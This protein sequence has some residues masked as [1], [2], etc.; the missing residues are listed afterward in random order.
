MSRHLFL[1]CYDICDDTRLRHVREQ[2]SAWRVQGQKSAFECW[3]TPAEYQQ[4]KQKL[5]SLIDDHVDLLHIIRLDPSQPIYR[6]G[7]PPMFDLD[8]GSFFIH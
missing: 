3:L 8:I 4:V 2:L 7:K 1:V 5:E 6:I